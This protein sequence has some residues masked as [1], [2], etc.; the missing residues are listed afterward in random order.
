MET[1]SIIKNQGAVHLWSI[2]Q[3]VLILSMMVK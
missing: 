3:Q 1:C 2:M